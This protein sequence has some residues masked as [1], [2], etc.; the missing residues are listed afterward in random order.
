MKIELTTGAVWDTKSE[1]QSEEARAWMRENVTN[2]LG[3]SPDEQGML[4]PELDKYQRPKRWV[5]EFETFTVTVEREYVEPQGFSWAM[6][7]D[8]VTVTTKNE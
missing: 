3:M 6:K 7:T 4:I 8:H 1:N 2:R 5:A